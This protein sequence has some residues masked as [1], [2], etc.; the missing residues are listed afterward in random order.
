MFKP[1]G[2]CSSRCMGGAVAPS[3]SQT[4]C[5]TGRQPVGGDWPNTGASSTHV[6]DVS[7]WNTCASSAGL[8]GR[9][10]AGLTG[11]PWFSQQT[12]ETVVFRTEP[13]AGL[14]GRAWFSKQL[15]ETMCFRVERRPRERNRAGRDGM[16]IMAPAQTPSCEYG[17]MPLN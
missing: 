3:P 14:T 8:T 12:E 6:A 1:S 11:R 9:T 17:H 5:S 2:A 7:C 15:S 16:S 10:W 4:C 13:S